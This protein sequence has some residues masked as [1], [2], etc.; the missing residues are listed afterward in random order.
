MAQMARYI[1]PG[2]PCLFGMRVPT[3]IR[4]GCQALLSV[5]RTMDEFVFVGLIR[6]VCAG[7]VRLIPMQVIDLYTRDVESRYK[8]ADICVAGERKK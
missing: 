1:V 5:A 7:E 6:A 2:S 4:R 8:L 3:M